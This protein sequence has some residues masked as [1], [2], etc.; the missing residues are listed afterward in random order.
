[1]TVENEKE[2]LE[3]K[4]NKKSRWDRISKKYSSNHE[5][6][7][8][9]VRKFLDLNYVDDKNMKDFCGSSENSTPDNINP[10][11]LMDIRHGSYKDVQ[12]ENIKQHN[13][14]IEM[15]MIDNELSK[16]KLKIKKFSAKRKPI[17]DETV[18]D[19]DDE[20]KLLQALNDTEGARFAYKND[21]NNIIVEHHNKI[22]PNEWSYEEGSRSSTSFSDRSSEKMVQYSA[23]DRIKVMTFAKTPQLSSKMDSLDIDENI[24]FDPEDDDV[25]EY[26]KN[27][28]LDFHMCCSEAICPDYEYQ[29]REFDTQSFHSMPNICD[30]DVENMMKISKFQSMLSVNESEDYFTSPA[31]E[32]CP[33]CITTEVIHESQEISIFNQK[34]VDAETEK[35]L[36]I[37]RMEIEEKNYQHL[38]VMNNSHSQ[39]DL[40][41]EDDKRI[42]DLLLKRQIE[43]ENVAREL[44]HKYF[45]QWLQK[46][47]IQKILKT[48]AFTNEDRVKKINGFLNKIRLEQNKSISKKKVQQPLSITLKKVSGNPTSKS[49]PNKKLKKD[50]EQK[51]KVQ[52]DIIEL[53]KL[54]LQRQERLITEMKMLKFSEMLKESKNEIKK[55]L[56]LAKRGNVKLRIKARCIQLAADIPLDPEEEDRRKILA[57]GLEVPKF[58]AKMQERAAERNMRHEEARER[59]IKLEQDK[60]E[61]KTAAEIAKKMED[62]EVRRKRM[63]EMRDKRLR[64]K[65][66]KI[67]REQERQKYMEDMV[68]VKA[69][70]A[71]KLMQRLGFKVFELLIQLKRTNHKKATIHRRRMCMKKHFL[72][73]HLN[74][75]AVWDFKKQQAHELYQVM[76]IKHHF[77]IWKHV[78]K[79]HQSK[80]L[81]AIDWYEVKITEKI[82]KHWALKTKQNKIL[83]IA[84]I[85][86]ADAHYNCQLKWKIVDHWR[87]LP[88]ILRIEK[89]TDIRR[90]KWRLKIWDM[91]P[92]YKPTCESGN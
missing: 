5:I 9:T 35:M 90:Q 19:E 50:Y 86:G 1:M 42:N 25:N 40:C 76:L 87:R 80:Y 77:A 34:I 37:K 68:K 18:S 82:M 89:E 72:L 64:E 7:S 52:Q 38:I 54:K 53:Q 59:R 79:I 48:N 20:E 8:E 11:I 92:D 58:L 69:F 62:E 88:A 74:T 3:S 51:L 22:E 26:E 13:S 43:A 17:F 47:T 30:A 67:I 14:L 24:E 33:C 49:L 29:H 83:E 70:H 36:I 91:L 6:T 55:E 63:L 71:R 65:N 31:I 16:Y 84:K 57:Q 61:V 4:I 41:S 21:A 10:Q 81:V 12:L 2:I 27:Y 46:T 73:W 85:R 60:E 23:P 44:L 66:M 78:R 45:Q 15:R 56:M 39:I 32:E 28:H 75:K